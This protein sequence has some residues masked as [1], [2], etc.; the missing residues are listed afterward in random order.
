[1]K[2][3]YR[4]IVTINGHNYQVSPWFS[5]AKDVRTW[6]DDNEIACDAILPVS[7]WQEVQLYQSEQGEI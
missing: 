4:A 7:S 5:S 6:L 1:M 2:L 3:K